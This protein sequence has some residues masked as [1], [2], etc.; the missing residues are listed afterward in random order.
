MVNDCL[1]IVTRCRTDLLLCVN[2]PW[3]FQLKFWWLYFL[4]CIRMTW[5][6]FL[7]S[8]NCFIIYQGKI[9]CLWKI[10]PILRKCLKKISG[11]C[12]NITMI[13]CF[14]WRINCH[15][16]W[17]IFMKITWPWQRMLYLMSCFIQFFFFVCRIIDFCVIGH[18]MSR[19]CVNVALKCALNIGKYQ[20]ASIKS[21]LYK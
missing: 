21:C 14:L 5:L 12:V 9:N 13:C 4:F 18:N 8:V 7:L 16:V 3:A 15:F 19:T 1:T 17:K 20:T 10:V 2:K 11:G 6:R